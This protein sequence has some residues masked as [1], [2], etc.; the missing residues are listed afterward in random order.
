MLSFLILATSPSFGTE[1]PGSYYNQPCNSQCTE[2]P[3]FAGLTYI[4]CDWRTASAGITASAVEDYAGVS[5][6]NYS[7]WGDDE[8]GTEF[9]CYFLDPNNSILNV[10]LLGSPY[11]DLFSF[12]YGSWRLDRPLSSGSFY[13]YANG[14]NGDDTLWG[15]NASSGTAAAVSCS[16]TSQCSYGYCDILAGGN[17]EDYIF[18]GDGSDACIGGDRAD[19]IFGGDGA[20]QILACGGNDN[21]EGGRGADVISGGTGL[22][23]ISGDNGKDLI[24]GDDGDDDIN[25]GSG[26]D[27]I[28]GGVGDDTIYGDDGDDVCEGEEGDDYIDGGAGDD[29][30]RGNQ[31]ND[32]LYGGS[33]SDVVCGGGTSGT[34][35]DYL[36]GALP[37][38][39]EPLDYADQLWSPTTAN[40]PNGF[41]QPN[42]ECG[43]ATTH[44][45]SW[46]GAQCD[47]SLLVRPGGCY[48]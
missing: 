14:Y 39:G 44:G 45:S 13:G 22:D 16:G 41:S 42:D 32:T 26:D 21:V 11:D 24:Y 7:I 35:A 6:P 8:S 5:D 46:A 25:G 27:T 10:V 12:N 3:V 23:T 38:I 36:S 37:G 47:Y 2:I 28:Y 31:D 9:C 30:V 19:D 33:G 29:W 18:G 17:N 15:S 1:C 34:G 20:D 43:H 48:L 40:T 4:E